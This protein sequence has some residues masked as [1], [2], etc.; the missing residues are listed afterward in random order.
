MKDVLKK[1]RLPLFFIS[2]AVMIS[3]PK[4]VYATKTTENASSFAGKLESAF[5]LKY[6]TLKKELAPILKDKSKLGVNLSEEQMISIYAYTAGAYKD[7]NSA[8]RKGNKKEIDKTAFFAS[9]LDS[10]L[11]ALPNYTGEVYRGTQLP[12]NVLKT[13]NVGSTVSDPAFLSTS[14]MGHY[15]GPHQMKIKSK[16]GKVISPFSSHPSEVEV[17]FA[18]N[19]KFKVVKISKNADNSVLFE[20]EEQ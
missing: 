18:P 14:V 8:L 20:L 13:Y 4:S 9:S 12:P 11:K 17:L 19:T 10:A 3:V 2:T 15:P 1:L 6:A 5:G 7:L 16:T